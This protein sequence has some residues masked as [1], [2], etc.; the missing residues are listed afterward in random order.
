MAADVF[1]AFGAGAKRLA[2]DETVKAGGKELVWGPMQQPFLKVPDFKEW[3]LDPANFSDIH[4]L[5][6]VMDLGKAIRGR[7]GVVFLMTELRSDAEQVMRFEQTLPNAR[8][9]IAGKEIKHGDRVAFGKGICQLFLE[10][11]VDAVPAGGL[12]LSPRF[13][14]SDAVKQEKAAWARAALK[15]KPYFDKVLKLA[16]AAD[17]A[18]RAR[19]VVDAL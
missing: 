13:W 8:A 2:G 5:R 7:T 14:A 6:R 19:K 9:W 12:H 11:R 4:R 15:R 16:P 10:V 18:K 17:V 1:T 3:E